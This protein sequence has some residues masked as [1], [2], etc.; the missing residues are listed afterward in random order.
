MPMP[1]L[2][3]CDTLKLAHLREIVTFAPLLLNIILLLTESSETKK[4]NIL[5]QLIFIHFSHCIMLYFIIL[6]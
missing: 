3:D 2:Y 1:H 4:K 6:M 5:F